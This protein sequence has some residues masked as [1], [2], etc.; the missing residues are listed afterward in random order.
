[1]TDM[2]GKRLVYSEDI[3]SSNNHIKYLKI[4]VFRLLT[5]QAKSFMTQPHAC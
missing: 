2:I 5:I 1:M 4:I 3:Y